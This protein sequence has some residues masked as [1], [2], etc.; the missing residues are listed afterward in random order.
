M[1]LG[2]SWGDFFI[3][4]YFWVLLAVAAFDLANYAF[5]RN[6]DDDS[7]EHLFRRETAQ[8]PFDLAAAHV[9]ADIVCVREGLGNPIDGFDAQIA[10]I[11]R[12]QVA[13]LATR[14]TRDFTDTGVALTDP[15]SGPDR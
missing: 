13:T 2:R 1:P 14:N 9:Y 12:S 4:P 7:N 10:A 8:N 15:W 3:K 6:L 11:C 5:A